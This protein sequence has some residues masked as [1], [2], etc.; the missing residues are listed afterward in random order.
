MFESAN[1]RIMFVEYF[2]EPDENELPLGASCG[3]G[4]GTMYM[5]YIEGG[6]KPNAP[7]QNFGH[8]SQKH[9]KGRYEIVVL[10]LCR[11]NVENYPLCSAFKPFV[12]LYH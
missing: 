9:G 6:L 7:R 5:P 11:I 2:V 12:K 1:V 3:D 10:E 4:K 8:L